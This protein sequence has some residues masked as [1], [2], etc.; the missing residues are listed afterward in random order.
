MKGPKYIETDNILK[1]F[2]ERSFRIHQEKLQKIKRRTNKNQ[3]YLHKRQSKH[4]TAPNEGD[5]SRLSGPGGSPPKFSIYS[6]NSMQNII[7]TEDDYSLM[8]MI[9]QTKRKNF[10]YRMM[11]QNNRIS[12]QN[13]A[14]INKLVK[15]SS[16]NNSLPH[17]KSMKLDSLNI[18][19]R[20]N[21]YERIIHENTKINRRLN[22]LKPHINM[23]QIAS[24]YK[25]QHLYHSRRLQKMKRYRSKKSIDNDNFKTKLPAIRNHSQENIRSPGAIG[26]PPSFDNF[27]KNKNKGKVSDSIKGQNKDIFNKPI[28]QVVRKEQNKDAEQKENLKGSVS[29]PEPPKIPQNSL[30]PDHEKKELE[31]IKEDK[32]KKVPEKSQQP[33]KP[34]DN[35]Q[36]KITKPEEISKK[37]EPKKLDVEMKHEEDKTQA[38][39]K[40]QEI[41]LNNQKQDHK[42]VGK[43]E[44]LKEDPQKSEKEELDPEK[45]EKKSDKEEKKSEKEEKKSE[46]EVIEEQPKQHL[47]KE[48]EEIKESHNIKE[49][50]KL[51]IVHENADQKPPPSRENNTNVL[52]K[53]PSLGLADKEQKEEIKQKSPEEVDSKLKEDKPKNEP[54]ENSYKQGSRES[55]QSLDQFDIN[56]IENE[57][58][59]S[60]TKSRN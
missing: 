2:R 54:G 11:Q 16:S 51:E 36:D 56:Q 46:K 1:K 38:E 9:K 43:P 4:E 33:S 42:E 6:Q 45:E 44:N 22:G 59:N 20:K 41:K 25:S 21:E 24:E 3:R 12:Q 47:K 18:H 8:S 10:E 5:F 29:K 26:I 34:E 13:T 17:R 15:I 39:N 31:P 32:Q 60:P 7:N 30:T 14:L 50:K 58:M 49:E 37:V 23:R 28:P 40:P 27:D 19:V 57:S 53:R 35:K 52:K 55:D 48:Q